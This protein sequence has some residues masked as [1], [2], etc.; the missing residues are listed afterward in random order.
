MSLEQGNYI[1]VTRKLKHDIALNEAST[2]KAQLDF[3]L[4]MTVN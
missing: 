1:R 2:M 3:M 4:Y